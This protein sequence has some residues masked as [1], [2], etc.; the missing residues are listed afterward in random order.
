[1]F[2][3]EPSS[4]WGKKIHFLV[5]GVHH[6]YPNDSK[7]LVMPPVVSVPLALLFYGMFVT[8]LGEGYIAPFFAGFLLGYVCYDTI[9]YATHHAPMKGRLGQWLKHH[10]ILHHY[11][12]N[13]RGFG[14]SSPTW[15]IVF[16]TMQREEEKAT[17]ES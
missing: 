9:H 17:V 5:H 13:A 11:R 15:D 3:Y 6:D 1:V 8:I 12:D 16:G 7:R 2:H 4:D 14:V 10:H